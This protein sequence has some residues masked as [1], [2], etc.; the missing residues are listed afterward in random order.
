MKPR[1]TEKSGAEDLFRERLE[2][3]IDLRHRLVK[4]AEAFDWPVFE[5]AFGALYDAEQGRP[6]VP[7][8]LMVGLHYLKHAF[9][10]SDEEVVLEW[11]ENPYWQYFCGEEYFQHRLP[12]DPS[13]MTRFRQRI[14]AAGCELML[15]QTVA[16]GLKTKTITRRSFASVTVD[17][18]VHDCMEAGGRATQE[19]KAEEK[20]VAFPTDARLYHKARIMLVRE[21]KRCGV[22]LRQSYVRVG[23]RA[24]FMH[25]RYLAARQNRRGRRQLKK[26]KVYLGRV[27][28]DIERKLERVAPVQR[29][30]LEILLTRARRLLKQ[31]RKDR[32]KL[33]SIHAPEVE[34]LAKGKT[35][36]RYEFGVKVSVATGTQNNFV[37]G[38]HSLPGNPYDGHTLR[39]ALDQVERMTGR[40]PAHCFVDRGYRGHDETDTTVIMAGQKR[41]MTPS[42]KRQLKRRN[43]V[44][45]VIGHMKSDGRLDRNY[46]KGTLGDAMN[47]LLV[48]AGHNIRLLLGFGFLR[49]STSC[50]HAVV[51][52][53][54]LFF[55]SSLATCD[56]A[57][58]PQACHA[59]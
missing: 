18:T 48:G 43:A 24:L 27:C 3:L 11:L 35:H 10:R 1:E 19:A 15:Q 22:T 38:M 13:Q 37:L 6:G 46:L 44:E 42:L 41:G 4:L 53:L 29:E 32:N 57:D 31:G 49:R 30:A 12:I 58:T 28:R 50:L 39:G 5:E 55:S 9:D 52:R 7:I 8:R 17:T 16:V 20:A 34:C 33:Y 21:A 56:P 36:K 47:A 45:P 51:R 14:G 59:A 54:G 25:N 26:L 40:R 2:N 23:K